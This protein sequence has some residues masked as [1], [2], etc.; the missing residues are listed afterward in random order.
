MQFCCYVLDILFLIIIIKVIIKKTS[1][2]ELLLIV[3]MSGVYANNII[4]YEV[5]RNRYRRIN[6]RHKCYNFTAQLTL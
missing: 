6:L 1:E 5:F 4:L 3:T 2:A